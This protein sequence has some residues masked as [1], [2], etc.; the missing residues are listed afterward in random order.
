[1]AACAGTVTPAP[2]QGRTWAGSGRCLP[3]ARGGYCWHIGNFCG[4]RRTELTVLARSNARVRQL[5]VV[6]TRPNCFTPA[7]HLVGDSA[8]GLLV[9]ADRPTVTAIARGEGV[10]REGD[11]FSVGWHY[12]YWY[13]LRP[14]AAAR[15]LG[16]HPLVAAMIGVEATVHDLPEF[17]GGPVI[18]M[19]PALLGS[20]RC[21]LS[22]FAPLHDDLRSRVNVLRHLPPAEVDALCDDLRA[23]A[24]SLG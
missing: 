22:F 9:A 11:S 23:G 2:R 4:R 14:E 1:M 6:R 5:G 10:V 13:G 20:R 19:R 7:G 15:A 18:L 21:D 16:L 12:E 8:P 17:C 3:S 24:E